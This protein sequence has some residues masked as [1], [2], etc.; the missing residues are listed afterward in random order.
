MEKTLAHLWVQ[1]SPA[2]SHQPPRS[3]EGKSRGPRFTDK[4]FMCSGRAPTG[5]PARPTSTHLL[6]P[7]AL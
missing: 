6:R 5:H 4:D 3:P 7:E 2:T 1:T